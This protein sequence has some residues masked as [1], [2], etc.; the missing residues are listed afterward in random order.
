[1]LE[2]AAKQEAARHARQEWA[3]LLPLEHSCFSRAV[4]E[5]G[6]DLEDL[7]AKGIR[8]QDPRI[9]APRL[10][11]ACK[12][13]SA[14]VLQKNIT[15][16]VTSE[17]GRTV[18]SRCDERYA[19]AEPALKEISEAEAIDIIIAGGKVSKINIETSGGKEARGQNAALERRLEELTQNSSTLGKYLSSQ[20]EPVRNRARHL[21]DSITRVL[22]SRSVSEQEA[23]R[24]QSEVASL[25][26]FEREEGQR[27]EQSLAAGELPFDSTAVSSKEEEALSEAYYQGAI[28]E[29][30]RHADFQAVGEVGREFRRMFERDFGTFRKSY[31]SADTSGTCTKKA[32]KW[33]CNVRGAL[34]TLA[35]QS[36]FISMMPR[37]QYVFTI[38]SSSE[39]HGDSSHISELIKDRLVEYGYTLISSD[40]AAELIEKDRI[41]FSVALMISKPEADLI[42]EDLVG[43]QTVRFRVF[44]LKNGILASSSA[45]SV[46]EVTH[47]I[48]TKALD[49]EKA[50][51]LQKLGQEAASRVS[52]NIL[53]R[54]ISY[55][56]RSEQQK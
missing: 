54:L 1:M 29:F 47:R 30:G 19:S 48:E 24:I 56:A 14:M 21:E 12:S 8:P 53:A 45:I 37:S 16:T 34:K 4:A 3:R 10:R 36:D 49:V 27:L 39:D 25:E 11:A 40:S 18:Q 32:A 9:M 46:R 28:R 41:D 42:G 2:Q 20:L 35:L 51:L 22:R 7:I 6:Y 31:F 38:N 17:S 52:Q 50:A 44:D 15:C 13:L 5:S 26:G 33:V 55:S 43:G 23:K